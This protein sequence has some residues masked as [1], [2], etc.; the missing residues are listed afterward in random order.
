MS[1]SQFQFFLSAVHKIYNILLCNK[2]FKENGTWNA[3][4]CEIEMKNSFFSWDSIWV[5]IAKDIDN[6]SWVC[7]YSLNIQKK[8]SFF[9]SIHFQLLYTFWWCWRSDYLNDL[10]NLFF[11]L[12]LLHTHS[13]L[14]LDSNSFIVDIIWSKKR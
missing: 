11:F 4:E 8:K 14:S 7:F 12:L 13:I 6:L 2:L 3:F 5:S 1:V 9:N 10:N